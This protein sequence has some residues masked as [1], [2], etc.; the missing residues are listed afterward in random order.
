MVTGSLNGRQHTTGFVV[1]SSVYHRTEEALERVAF[2]YCED[3][4][5]QNVVYFE[6]RFNPF[7]GVKHG[8]TPEQYCEGMLSGLER[9][10]KT[11]GIKAR[12]ILCFLRNDPG[13]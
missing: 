13:L 12:A 5:R 6:Y 8:L 2:E 9:G 3:A 1:H 7:L 4:D 10:Q 11:F